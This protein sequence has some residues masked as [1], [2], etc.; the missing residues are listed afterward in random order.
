MEP[1]LCD[2]VRWRTGR[3]SLLLCP[4]REPKQTAFRLREF[5]AADGIGLKVTHAYEALAQ[6]LGYANWNT[7]QALLN[8]TALPESEA[9]PAQ[10]L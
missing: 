2:A 6:T 3:C 8:A 4:Q 5:L 10:R 1:S 9:R 7:L